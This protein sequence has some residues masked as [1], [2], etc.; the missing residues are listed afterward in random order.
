LRAL[1]EEV[2]SSAAIASSRFRRIRSVG[3]APRLRTGAASIVTGRSEWHSREDERMSDFPAT[4]HDSDS[5]LAGGS[6]LDRGLLQSLRTVCRISERRGASALGGRRGALL[7]PPADVSRNCSNIGG[8]GVFQTGP[9][10][11]VIPNVPQPQPRAHRVR[12]YFGPGSAPNPNV[13]GP[14]PTAPAT[15]T[16]AQARQHFGPNF[17]PPPCWRT[18][19]GPL[20]TVWQGVTILC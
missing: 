19:N 12:P 18:G 8:G 16:W 13:Y 4:S 7:P 6:D 14:G 5:G 15:M 1:R 10:P 20:Y 3:N 17:N 11:S 9:G 2:S